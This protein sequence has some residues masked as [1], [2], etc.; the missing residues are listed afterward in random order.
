MALAA[1]LP[2]PV[3]AAAPATLAIA[4]LDA[5][6]TDID[7]GVPGPSAGDRSVFRAPVT[8]G[9]GHGGTV[10]GVTTTVRMPS[11]AAPDGVAVT[12][13]AYDFGAGSTLVLAGVDPRPAGVE[14]PAGTELR[15]TILGGTGRFSGVRG[16]LASTVGADGDWTNTATLVGIGE[17]VTRTF[18]FRIPARPALPGSGPVPPFAAGDTATDLFTLLGPGGKHTGY[19]TI[20][21]VD[22]EVVDGDPMRLALCL[23]AFDLGGGDRI[24]LA[25]LTPTPAGPP[26]ALRPTMPL[27][28]IGGT[29]RYAGARGEDV[30]TFTR[31]GATHAIRLVGRGAPEGSVGA[32]TEIALAT[33]DNEA[34]EIELGGGSGTSLGD[35]WTWTSRTE[36]DGVVSGASVG[37]L[38]N[39]AVDATETTRLGLAF[40]VRPGG[41]LVVASLDAY[42]A[43][44]A[45]MPVG[46]RRVRALVGGTGDAL[47]AAGTVAMGRA[48]D[49]RFDYLFALE[50]SAPE[51]R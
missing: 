23:V 32:G 28:V 50:G 48:D 18:A 45:P 16:A 31:A 39:V 34:T 30:V 25:G 7:A 44:G 40:Y 49:D 2:L 14:P 27:A 42:P 20:T 38:T 4:E 43:P 51:A 12:F 46:T 19:A 10:Y 21:G 11:D 13:L 5:D 33:L 26:G 47:G 8:I 35:Q 29:G 15:R 3:A 24:Y 36:E 22:A 9:G 41:D 37:L 1:A 17:P 6:R